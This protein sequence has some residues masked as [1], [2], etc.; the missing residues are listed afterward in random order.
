MYKLVHIKYFAFQKRGLISWYRIST[1]CI[2]VNIDS[3]A[4]VD[5]LEEV[6]LTVVLI[7]SMIVTG[8]SVIVDAVEGGQM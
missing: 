5:P 1:V 7:F 6:T 4:T 3:I 8:S 2:K